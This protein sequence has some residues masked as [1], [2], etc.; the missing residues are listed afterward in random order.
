MITVR[1][2]KIRDYQFFVFVCAW[3]LNLSHMISQSEWLHWNR[4]NGK[5][6]SRNLWQEKARRYY[7]EYVGVQ[8]EIWSPTLCLWWAKS[9]SRWGETELKSVHFPTQ[10][11]F[12]SGFFKSK[13]VMSFLCR[14]RNQFCCHLLQLRKKMQQSRLQL[15]NQLFVAQNVTKNSL[16][17]RYVSPS[18]LVILLIN[19]SVEMS[20]ID[21]W[22]KKTRSQLP[23]V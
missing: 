21:L 12:R 3:T 13:Y 23:T 15:R 18:L 19:P 11:T 17:E 1:S 22:P 9:R 8:W 20:L 2:L 10:V 4:Q 14:F 16:Q 5:T 7:W 6:E